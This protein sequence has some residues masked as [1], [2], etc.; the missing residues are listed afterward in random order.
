MK[1]R[2]IQLMQESQGGF[3]SGE[4]LSKALGCSRTAVWKH[5][6][7]L[8]EDGYAFEAVPKRG[9][10]LLRAPDRLNIERLQELLRTRMLGRSAH[11][12]DTLDS[13]Q[14][15][16]HKLVAEGAAEGTL[17]IA[18][19]QTAGRGRMG[20]QWHS[21]K[22]TGVYMSLVLKPR[23]PLHFTPQLT[24]LAAV[25]LCRGIKRLI[26]IPVGIKWPNDLLVRGKKISGIL[27]ESSAE[28]ERL[29]Y[30]IAGMGI[31]VNL[32]P[33]DY[34]PELRN[35]AT[36]LAIE[37]GRP[38]E[39][40]PLIAAVLEEFEEL[41]ALYHEQGFAPIRLMWEAYSA[42]LHRPV[43]VNTHQ[44]A[45][46]GVAEALDDTGGLMVR[47]PDGQRLRIYSGEVEL[48]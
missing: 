29:R 2:I 19:R 8:R 35:V 42:S 10:R 22:G 12:F 6:D 5:I 37:A 23:V 13:T 39:R 27:L 15:M 47:L 18:E 41:Y 16:A 30:V 28:D 14:T 38:I 44:G 31:G 25:A 43:R 21:P 45:V 26:D 3:V 33:D 9:Y 20:R 40:E 11:L 7:A 17:V 32:L 4:Q 36:S 24:L 1:E 34:P 46:D 48:R